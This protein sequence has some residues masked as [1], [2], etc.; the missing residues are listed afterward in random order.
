MSE[1]DAE[2][3]VM[4]GRKKLSEVGLPARASSTAGNTFAPA[5]A[6][7]SAA[8]KAFIMTERLSERRFREDAGVSAFGDLE[9]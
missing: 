1:V 5:E 2:F 4:I 8:A 3:A 6:A 9:G 7:A